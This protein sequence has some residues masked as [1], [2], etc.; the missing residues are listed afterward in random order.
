MVTTTM[1]TATVT[2][3]PNPSKRVTVRERDAYRRR[4]RALGWSQNEAARQIGKN[5]GLFSRWLRG[6]MPSKIIRGLINERLEVAERA[7]QERAS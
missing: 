4:I 1:S 6:E 7:R 3:F 5:E 2:E